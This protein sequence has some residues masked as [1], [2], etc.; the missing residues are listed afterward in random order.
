MKSFSNETLNFFFREFCYFYIFGSCQNRMSSADLVAELHQKLCNKRAFSTGEPCTCEYVPLLLL[1]HRGTLSTHWYM[2]QN[3]QPM[4]SMSV[5]F[6]GSFRTVVFSRFLKVAI[7]TS[8]FINKLYNGK[9]APEFSVSMLK[10]TIALVRD[11]VSET[12]K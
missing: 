1:F 2:T 5:L 7:V 9:F 10:E 8:N 6:R 12:R 11:Y 4:F 3:I